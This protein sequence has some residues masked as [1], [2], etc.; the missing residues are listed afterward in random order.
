MVR[1]V[2]SRPSTL[3]RPSSPF[4][5]SMGK[6]S[7]CTS[8]TAS[9]RW[10]SFFRASMSSRSRAA[11]SNSIAALASCISRSISAISRSFLPSITSR[12]LRICLRYSSARHAEVARGRTLA[13]AVQQARPK[14]T[15]AV[16]VGA[17]VQRTGA[18]LEEA[19]QHLHR[20]PQRAG[21]GERAVELDAAPPRRPRELDARE[22]FAYSDLQIGKCLVVLQLDVETRL[23]VL[24]EP[25]FEK[26]G[27]HLA[28]GGQEIDVGDELARGRRC[29]GPRPPALVK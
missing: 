15:P 25:R 28:V 1:G 9:P 13:D 5:G 18:E 20:L 17:D 8:R 4:F 14:P 22:F 26:Q 7:G 27:V 21:A 3:R 19:L 12:S 10:P 11:F 23:H 6:T 2:F 24:D 16:V 29:A